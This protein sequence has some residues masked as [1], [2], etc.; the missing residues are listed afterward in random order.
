MGL[1]ENLFTEEARRLLGEER[2]RLGDELEEEAFREALRSRGEPVEVTANDVRI[3]TKRF[4]KSDSRF[5]SGRPSFMNTLL[6][7]YFILGVV[8]FFGGVFYPYL[9]SLWDRY[10]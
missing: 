8:I 2:K 6:K 10:R 1:L 3:A 4:V 7:T 9:H 5:D